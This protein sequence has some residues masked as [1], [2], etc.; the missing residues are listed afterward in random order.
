[1]TARILTA[2]A[3]DQQAAS[4]LQTARALAEANGSSLA[5]CHVVPNPYVGSA[6]LPYVNAAALEVGEVER[7]AREALA[8]FVAQELPGVPVELFVEL[9]G[10]ASEVV[11]R[12]DEWRA[13]LIV[14][15]SHAQGA[16]E[17]ALLGSVASGIVRYAHCPVYV[18]RPPSGS[19]R[20]V[21]T[22]DLSEASLPAITAAA[23]EAR[24]LGL[25]LSALYVLEPSWA[26][27]GAAAAAPFGLT[28]AVPSAEDQRQLLESARATLAAVMQGARAEGEAVVLQGSA[29]PTIVRYAEESGAALVV[30]GTRGRTGIKRILLGSVAETVASRVHCSVLAIRQPG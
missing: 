25:P 15:G 21:A 19:A 17:R 22:T 6:L 30:L 14:T 1:M 11:R 2:V 7:S 27:L 23:S 10:A 24:R 29:A 16:L 18:T 12:A 3:F 26:G 8:K 13:E 9:G 5:V 4:V 28:P 20:V